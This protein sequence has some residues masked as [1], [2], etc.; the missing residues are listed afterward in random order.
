[1]AVT[2]EVTHAGGPNGMQKGIGRGVRDAQQGN[3]EAKGI[4]IIIHL[5]GKSTER[6]APESVNTSFT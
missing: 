6:G 1:M 5:L 3:P 2:D 4:K